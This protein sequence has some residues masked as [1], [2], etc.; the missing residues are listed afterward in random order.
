MKSITLL[1]VLTASIGA[2]M[3][4]IALV[5]LSILFLQLTPFIGGIMFASVGAI[6]LYVYTDRMNQLSKELF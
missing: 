2:V 3:Y 4:G 5:I 1:T 6:T